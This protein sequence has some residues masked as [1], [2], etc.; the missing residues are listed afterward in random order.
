M[1]FGQNN[2]AMIH[3]LTMGDW[4]VTRL[5]KNVQQM[6]LAVAPHSEVNLTPPLNKDDKSIPAFVQAHRA[7]G[8]SKE[9]KMAAID[10]LPSYNTGAMHYLFGKCYPLN[11]IKPARQSKV[12]HAPKYINIYLGPS[13]MDDPAKGAAALLD[14]F[15]RTQLMR[16]IPPLLHKWKAIMQVAPN[17]IRIKKMKTRWGTCNLTAKRIWLSLYLAQATSPCIEYVFVHEMVHLFEANHSARFYQ[18]MDTFLPAWRERKKELKSQ[19]QQ[20]TVD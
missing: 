13:M 5:R 1:S 16:Q 10:R 12:T 14:R 18:L 3:K 20:M 7:W 2:I 15:Y 17:E 4:E 6:Q 8:H 11:V 9:A 19:Q